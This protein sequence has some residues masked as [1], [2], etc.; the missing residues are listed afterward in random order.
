MQDFNEIF[1]TGVAPES[2]Q[3][4]RM[5]LH[6]KGHGAH[7]AALDSYRALGI[8]N[9]LK[10]IMSMVL[11]ERLNTFLVQ[12]GALSREQLGFRRKSGTSEAVL[13]LSE[14]VRN[15]AEGRPS[16]DRIC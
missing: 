13:A 16:S 8:G 11:E 3:I 6:Y 12:T 5:L 14:V 9:C 1:R 4:Y 15:A 7:P 2:W 10:K